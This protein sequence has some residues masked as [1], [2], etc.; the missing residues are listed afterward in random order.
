MNPVMGGKGCPTMDVRFIDA[1]HSAIVWSCQSPRR[2]M[3]RTLAISVSASSK[4]S[5]ANK[6]RQRT[7]MPP[8]LCLPAI[9]WTYTSSAAKRVCLMRG[10]PTLHSAS[11]LLLVEGA[12][13]IIIELGSC[14]PPLAFTGLE[15]QQ[16]CS[17]AAGN[18]CTVLAT[19]R[20]P[21]HRVPPCWLR[22]IF[23]GSWAVLPLPVAHLSYLASATS[24]SSISAWTTGVGAAG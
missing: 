15:K 7:A 4:L 6:A 16:T 13:V 14:T 12:M 10:H 23:E 8:P 19:G 22:Q 5:L 9:Q 11:L 20:P 18:L 24:S 2:S 21:S 1:I 17:V 3:S